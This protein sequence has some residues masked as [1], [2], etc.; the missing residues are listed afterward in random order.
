MKKTP[1]KTLLKVAVSVGIT[2]FVVRKVLANESMDDLAAQLA[3][4][5]WPL[6]GL[7]FLA[8][9][10][11]MASNLVRWRMLLLGQGIEV[12]W[13]H[14]V[15]TF[16]IGRFVGSFTPSTT[17][18]DGWRMYDIAR[19][20]GATARS[21]SV[22]LV[23]KVIGFF[24]LSV[25]LLATLPW[26]V[27]YLGGS[28]ILLVGAV[29]FPM[30]ALALGVLL[31]PGLVRK[32]FERMPE[33]IRRK[34]GSTL[35][36]VTAYGERRRHLLLAILFGFPV[37]GCTILIYLCTARAL[38]VDT[39][40]ADLAFVSLMAIAATLL[41][42]SIAGVG[43]REGTFVGL[44]GTVGIATSAAALT[45][46]LGYLCGEII[47]LF[48]GL[49]LLARP[50]GYR[51]AMKGAG[52]RT[53][54][55]REEAGARAL[56]VPWGAAVQQGVAAGLL[57]GV[58]LGLAEAALV[59]AQ[60]A[61]PRDLSVLPYAAVTYGLATAMAG[62]TFA[63]AIA[64]WESR[65]GR[66]LDGA[67]LWATTGAGLFAGLG[68]VVARFRVF[69][70]VF[71]ENLR[72]MSGQGLAVQLALVVA[73]AG[74]FWIGRK[75]ALRLVQRPGRVLLRAWGSPAAAGLVALIVAIVSFLGSPRGANGAGAAATRGTGSG[76]NVLVVVVDTLRADAV[77]SYGGPAGQTPNLD[78]LASQGVLFENAFAQAS[79]TRPSFATILT[80][81]FPSSHRTIFKPDAL[82]DAVDTMPE[83][84][85]RAGWV[86]SGFVTNYNVAPYFNFDQGFDEYRYLEPELV[87]WAN[88]TQ[89]RLALYSVVRLAWERFAPMRPERFYRDARETTD[90]AIG[91]LRRRPQGPF[92][93]FVGYMDPHDP[94]FRHP[95]DGTAVA[96]VST[97]SPDPD[98]AAELR[99]LYD[100]E[101]KYWDGHFGRLLRA[102][103]ENTVV[104]VTSDHG[105]EFAEHGGF[106]HG[107][108]LYDEQVRIPLVARLPSGSGVVAG[109]RS[110]DW[111]RHVDM[112]RTVY[113]LC[114]VETP[115]GDQGR[116][117]FA[118]L[119]NEPLRDPVF[120]EEDHEGN[121]LF[122]VRTFENGVER[123][124]VVANE[125]NPRGLAPEEFFDLG[126]DPGERTNLADRSADGV[127]HLR[128]ELDRQSRAAS[129]G[130]VESSRV[131]ID[132]SSA[133]RLR[134][135]GYA[136]GEHARDRSADAGPDAGE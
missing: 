84:L 104:L 99:A 87:L 132:Q 8:Q 1:I 117:L 7:A 109:T 20:S 33:K 10:S 92:F 88:D 85:G 39:P 48:G 52:V 119:G 9:I 70:D 101:V 47:S 115:A 43:V 72:P 103:P 28:A 50:A 123:K 3:A 25:L 133:E 15:G 32:L 82:P 124:L 95:L 122:S 58:F 71:H 89:S 86:T 135:L 2:V 96:R 136:G 36:A 6:L 29:V 16:L 57:A 4:V 77:S 54:E 53:A 121:V 63:A 131:G 105:E 55:E 59:L 68:L 13:R 51:M 81:R 91:W 83:V 94:Y 113:E 114:G 69:R 93:L 46:F 125:R 35:D 31:R 118:N 100:G 108:T 73:A 5:S 37:H 120:A 64:W 66:A 24:V 102:L 75:V 49:V 38:S 23:A 79:W 67:R 90:A 130:A 128:E 76:P 78:R 17:G 112:A 41:P 65:G 45:G 22:I 26:G 98:R 97:P 127:T 106:W 18:L 19:H 34:G 116:S 126:R 111:V 129:E 12:P 60:S 56:P 27:R 107:T 110:L 30:G 74:V 42:I 21:V 134:A 62:T 14:L 11:A 44:L 80:G 61:R 40:A